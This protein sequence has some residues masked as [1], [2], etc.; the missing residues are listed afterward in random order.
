VAISLFALMP[1]GSA[2]SITAA[3]DV[4]FGF[5]FGIVDCILWEICCGI[6]EKEERDV[7]ED[8]AFIEFTI[9]VEVEWAHQ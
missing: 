5:N 9:S 3:G 6:E 7:G 1:I 4:S 2:I 8:V